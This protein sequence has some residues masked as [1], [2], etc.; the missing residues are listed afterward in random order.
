[1]GMIYYS[2]GY[3][4]TNEVVE[5][6]AVDLSGEC[7]GQARPKTRTQLD[8]ALGKVLLVDNAFQPLKGPFELEAL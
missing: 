7:V 6:S 2:L 4:G 1:M 3:L 5:C 8:K